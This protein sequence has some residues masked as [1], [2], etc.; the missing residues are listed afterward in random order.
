MDAELSL[1]CLVRD[2]ISAVKK[3]IRRE[4]RSGGE[5]QYD[6]AAQ[7]VGRWLMAL[8]T[9]AEIAAVVNKVRPIGAGVKPVG[10]ALGTACSATAGSSKADT[11]SSATAGSSKADTASSAAAEAPKADTASSATSGS[12]KTDTVCSA[13]SSSTKTDTVCSATAEAPKADTACSAPA[14]AAAESAF[15]S[16]CELYPSLASTQAWVFGAVAS[17]FAQTI[18]YK[19]LKADL[20][21]CADKVDELIE[22]MVGQVAKAGERPVWPAG[23]VVRSDSSRTYLGGSY[24]VDRSDRYELLKGAQSEEAA[25]LASIRYNLYPSARLPQKHTDALFAQG[26]TCESVG[27]PFDAS[28]LFKGGKTH[29]L[30]GRG[31]F[32]TKGTFC[33]IASERIA[34]RNWLVVIPDC[35]VYANSHVVKLARALSYGKKNGVAFTAVVLFPSGLKAAADLVPYRFAERRVPANLL[36]ASHGSKALPDFNYWAASSLP[37]DKADG[38]RL[39]DCS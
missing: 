34:K 32:G 37:R 7:I 5:L 39:L 24:G 26:I 9:E 22:Q 3:A 29:T 35:P 8:K 11:A 4:R 21:E 14:E 16:V 13:T 33:T 31:E 12:T 38:E 6:K 25:L 17:G 28:F 18:S 23:G 19:Q 30:H 15:A 2:L 20:T 27:S 36:V 1:L 10:A